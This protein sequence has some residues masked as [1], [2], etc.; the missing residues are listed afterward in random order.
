MAEESDIIQPKVKIKVFG[1]GGGG[2]NVLAR[3]EMNDALDIETLALNSEAQQLSRVSQKGLKVLSIGEALTNGRGM[4]GDVALGEKA[5]RMET[6]KIRAAMEGADLLVVAATMGGGFGT[7]VAPVVAQIAKE[8]GILT[9]GLVTEPFG[10][11]GIRKQCIA[12]AGIVK[13]QSQMDALIVVKN[14]RLLKLPENRT[15]KL[16][17]AFDAADRFLMQ[18]INCIAE[19]ILKTGVVNV[20]FADVRTI[21]RHSE[22]SDALLGI[23]RSKRSAV[24]AVK[25]AV[26]S[27]LF[28]RDLKGARAVILNLIG[29]ENLSMFDVDE[30]TNYIAKAADDEVDLI[31]GTVIEKTMAGEVQATVIATDFSDSAVLKSPK[32]EMPKQ[33]PEPPKPKIELTPPTFEEAKSEKSHGSFAIPAFKLADEGEQK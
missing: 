9:V 19:L 2:N 30:A 31:F 4:G 8:A 11:E 16:T 28:S 17:E 29:D 24:D 33:K 10:F 26:T 3:M 22:S 5:A 1:V 21:F 12:G 15:L 18:S 23:G 32:V 13:M 20:D 6:A 27:P 7:G 14:E 25:A